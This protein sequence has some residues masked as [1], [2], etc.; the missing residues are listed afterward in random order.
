G[1]F[2]QSTWDQYK[3]RF[4]WVYGW[5][6]DNTGASHLKILLYAVYMGGLAMGWA[7]RDFRSKRSYRAWL[8]LCPLL[9][10]SYANLDKDVHD[11]YLVHIMAPAIAVLALVLDWIL[12]TRRAPVL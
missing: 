1:G 4:L 7:M 6:P 8:I 11:F 2:F 10:F 12:K 3:E 9:Y 5:H